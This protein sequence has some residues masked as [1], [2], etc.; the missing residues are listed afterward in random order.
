MKALGASFILASMC[1]FPLITHSTDT[2]TAHLALA[3]YRSG[4]HHTV[5]H[6][7]SVRIVMLCVCVS[8]GGVW[9]VVVST[10][11]PGGGSVGS[12]RCV[13]QGTTVLYDLHSVHLKTVSCGSRKDR[14]DD[15]VLEL[16]GQDCLSQLV[17]PIC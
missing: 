16:S 1:L 13:G 2:L 12:C 7:P 11:R 3:I 4:S 6:S 15:T 5:V 17:T 9:S 8:S 14:T 10:C